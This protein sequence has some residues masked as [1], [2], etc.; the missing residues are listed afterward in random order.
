MLLL[1]LEEKAR[2]KRER[3]DALE[4][5]AAFV[6][7]MACQRCKGTS[8]RVSLACKWGVK[9]HC[10]MQRPPDNLYAFGSAGQSN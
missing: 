3:E 4:R 8:I 5:A 10:G 7:N 9:G 6:E 2:L 1:Q